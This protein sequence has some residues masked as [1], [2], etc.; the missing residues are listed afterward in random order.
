MNSVRTG[1]KLLFPNLNMTKCMTFICSYLLWR[2]FYMD[3]KNNKKLT[4]SYKLINSIFANL[5]S[6]QVK[7]TGEIQFQ[8]IVERFRRNDSIPFH[9]NILHRIFDI[10]DNKIKL[11]F[12][13]G[14]DDI[15]PIIR[16]YVCPPKPDYGCEIVFDETENPVDEVVFF[17]FFERPFHLKI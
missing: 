16:T 6:F 15:I 2:E 12:H 8:R 3:K 1:K 5:N 11:Q 7:K 14:E 17:F 10:A 4:V 9:E 13:Y